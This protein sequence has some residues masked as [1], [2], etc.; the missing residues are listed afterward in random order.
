MDNNV[1]AGSKNVKGKESHVGSN[2]KAASNVKTKNSLH[3][4]SKA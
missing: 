3:S 4:N 1:E 2:V